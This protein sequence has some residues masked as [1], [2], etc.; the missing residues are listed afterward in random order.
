MFRTRDP[1]LKA[2]WRIVRALRPLTHEQQQRVLQWVYERFVVHGHVRIQTTAPVP[3]AA[4]R[5]TVHGPGAQQ[6]TCTG[7]DAATGARGH[8]S[9]DARE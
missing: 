2:A 4:T 6:T 7:A 1:E 8:A 9:A 5:A 3:R